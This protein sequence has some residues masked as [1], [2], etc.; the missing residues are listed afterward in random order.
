VFPAHTKASKNCATR[1]NDGFCPGD[2]TGGF[3]KIVIISDVHS[4]FAALDALPEESYDQLW[5]LGDLVDYG[6]EPNEVVQWVRDKAAVCVRGNHDHAV[7]FNVDPQCSAQFRKLAASTRHFTQD[8]VGPVDADYLRNLPIQREVTVE[9]TSFYLVHAMPTDPLFGYCPEESDRWKQEVS[10]IDSGVLVVGHTH[11]PFVRRLGKT[12]IVNPGSVGQPKTGRPYA[13][14]AVW[15]NGNIYLK[16]YSYPIADTIREISAMPIS[17]SDRSALISVLK[18]G[19]LTA[20]CLAETAPI[21]N[22]SA[23]SKEKVRVYK[24]VRL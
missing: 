4:N 8:I 9:A 1:L 12:V 5:C 16:E 23:L 2:H 22:N 21:A 17:H 24:N 13:C 14:Y 19:V 10:W 3:V 11:T 15:E 18:T 6:P 20:G 7:G